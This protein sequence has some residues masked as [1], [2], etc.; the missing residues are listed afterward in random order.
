MAEVVLVTARILQTF[1][2]KPLP[3]ASFPAADAKITLRP[4]TVNLVL[5][6][7]TP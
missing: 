7:R 6:R 5:E 2:L 4:S 1:S 3:G